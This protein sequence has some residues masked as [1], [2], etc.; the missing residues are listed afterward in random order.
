MGGVE[1]RFRDDG[2][3]DVLPSLGQWLKL[4]LPAG[5][6]PDIVQPGLEIRSIQ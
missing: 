5:P 6:F 1:T 3:D 2:F 4:A